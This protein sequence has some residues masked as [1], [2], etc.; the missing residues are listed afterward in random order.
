VNKRS[1]D[2][3]G[4][5]VT[6]TIAIVD[7]EKE[8]EYLYSMLLEPA[9]ENK[10]VNLRF[11]DDAR[12]FV[13]WFKDHKPDLILSDINMP[14]INGFELAQKVREEGHKIL[15]Y[16]ISGDDASEYSQQMKK[17]GPCRYFSKPLDFD[18]VLALIEEDLN[19]PHALN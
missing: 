18:Q 15:T 16:F 9:V 6:K 2:A 5:F 13:E 7:D 11:F 3:Q 10:I 1:D 8:M 12:N 14:H 17:F 19:L 4:E